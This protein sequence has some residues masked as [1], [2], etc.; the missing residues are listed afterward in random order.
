[1]ARLQF[2]GIVVG[3]TLLLASAILWGGPLVGLQVPSYLYLPLLVIV[4]VAS[5]YLVGHCTAE[6]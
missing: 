5:L 2:K 4:I 3:G 6:S 1:M